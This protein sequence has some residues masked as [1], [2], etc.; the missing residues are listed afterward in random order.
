MLDG[1]GRPQETGDRT[2]WALCCVVFLSSRT[3]ENGVMRIGG[4]WGMGGLDL[5]MRMVE[6]ILEG[7]RVERFVNKLSIHRHRNLNPSKKSIHPSFIFSAH[8]PRCCPPGEEI[9][10]SASPVS[11]VS[12]PMR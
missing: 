9:S 7:S 4:G 3:C 8:L 1:R 10:Q 12:Y 11:P 6:S 2:L 5:G